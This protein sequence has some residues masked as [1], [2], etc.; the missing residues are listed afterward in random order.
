MS[1]T[2]K[3]ISEEPSL[4]SSYSRLLNTQ[5]PTKPR[6][7]HQKPKLLYEPGML[8]P[9]PMNVKN[10]TYHS[11]AGE[12]NGQ[13]SHAGPPGARATSTPWVEWNALLSRHAYWRA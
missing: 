10:F 9:H 1:Y 2:V 11:H 3:T 6:Y 4:E 12:L 13:T 7:P 5:A 8:Y